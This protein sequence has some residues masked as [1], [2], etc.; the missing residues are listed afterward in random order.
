MKIVIPLSATAAVKIENVPYTGANG[1]YAS[2]IP[3]YAEGIVEIAEELGIK[4]LD[5]NVIHTTVCYSKTPVALAD[6]PAIGT[7]DEFR[8]LCNQVDH[9]VGHKGQTCIVLKL[10]SS[11]IV[12]ANANLQRRGAVHTFT[13][14][15]PHITLTDESAPVDAA[16]QERIDTINKRLAHNPLWLTFDR[17]TVGDLK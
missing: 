3:Q 2:L 5:P 12:A 10:V 15:V 1:L 14:Y 11:D 17:Y 16:M 9:W 13:P 8:A 4:H 6:L 7:S